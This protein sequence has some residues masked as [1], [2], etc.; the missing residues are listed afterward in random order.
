[1]GLDR[2]EFFRLSALTTA[3][4]SVA[5]ATSASAAP[6]STLGID[7]LQLGVRAGGARH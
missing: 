7:A 5:L 4:P 6:M 3:V 1:M 2:R